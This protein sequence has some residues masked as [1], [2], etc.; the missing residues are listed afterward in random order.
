L[1]PACYPSK[2]VETSNESE[3]VAERAEVEIESAVLQPE[4]RP[5]PGSPAIGPVIR[6][7]ADLGRRGCPSACATGKRSMLTFET[8]MQPLSPRRPIVRTATD[9]QLDREELDLLE[10]IYPHST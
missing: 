6:G 5:A 10:E 3:E 8:R 2:R 1:F 4:S 7:A 9:T